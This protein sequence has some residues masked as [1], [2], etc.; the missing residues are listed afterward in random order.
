[1]KRNS[2][3]R[4]VYRYI[5]SYEKEITEYPSIRLVHRHILPKQE[6]YPLECNN[7]YSTES[8]A[9]CHTNVS[10]PTSGLKKGAA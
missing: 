10:S 7:V 5:L 3:T 6:Y 8:Q 1:M 9:K 2:S 4:K